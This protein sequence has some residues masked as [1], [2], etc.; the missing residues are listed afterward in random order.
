MSM[1]DAFRRIDAAW[2]EVDAWDEQQIAARQAGDMVLADDASQHCDDACRKARQLEEAASLMAV[3]GPDDAAAALA[4]VELEL[5]EQASLQ[6][7]DILEQM[8]RLTAAV[9]EWIKQSPK[10]PA[11]A[12]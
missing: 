5:K 4:R 10:A 1:V 6:G 11:R 12:T 8:A 7:D 2:V 3:T 9:N